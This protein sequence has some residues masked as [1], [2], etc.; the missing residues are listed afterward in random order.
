MTR[1]EVEKFMLQNRLSVEDVFRNTGN[2]PNDIRGWLSGKKKIPWYIT[3][4]SLTKK[5]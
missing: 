5:S 2:K 3:E 4:E 1:Q